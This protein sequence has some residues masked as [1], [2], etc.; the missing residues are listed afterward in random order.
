MV[1]ELQEKYCEGRYFSTKISNP[2]F[3]M[4]AKSFGI[5]GVSV[6]S[7]SELETAFAAAF[8]NDNPFVIDF[9]V[10]DM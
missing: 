8:N 3:I 7:V 9:R 2:D 6:E 4:L 1:R 5:E 10:K